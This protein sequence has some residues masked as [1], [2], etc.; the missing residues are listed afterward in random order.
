M[1]QKTFDL[2]RQLVSTIPRGKVTTYGAVA[3]A[4]KLK[5]PRIVGWAL[6]GNQNPL[7]PCHRVVRRDG[8]LAPEF[9]LGGREEQKRRL[10]PEGIAFIQEFQVDLELHFWQP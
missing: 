5:T 4:L 1:P 3:K 9:S 6:R 7:V 2:V 8:A 10:L